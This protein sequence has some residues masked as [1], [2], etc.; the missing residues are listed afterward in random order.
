[1]QQP[2]GQ[3]AWTAMAKIF[4]NSLMKRRRIF[5]GKLKGIVMRPNRDPDEYLTEV[6]QQWDEFEGIG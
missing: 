1:M 5:M 6:F 2:D 3:A 4:V